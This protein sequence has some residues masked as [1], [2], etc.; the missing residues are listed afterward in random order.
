MIIIR[1]F[2]GGR[3][4][5]TMMMLDDGYDGSRVCVSLEVMGTS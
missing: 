3:M 1:R 2:V 4:M 5:M